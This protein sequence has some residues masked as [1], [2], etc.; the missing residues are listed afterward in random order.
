M[1]T[2]YI[3]NPAA[4]NLAEKVSKRMGVT[5]TEAVIYSLQGQL[6]N[7]ARPIDWKKVEAIQKKIAALPV[8]D[9]RTDDEILGYE[10]F[11]IP[12]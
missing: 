7:Q 11:G 10:E 3:K 5:L 2:L 12:R 6:N 8:L 9:S 1:R 4:H